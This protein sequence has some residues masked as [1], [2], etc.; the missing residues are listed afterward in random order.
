MK[1]SLIM[2]IVIGLPVAF[3]LCQT[4]QDTRLERGQDETFFVSF[5]T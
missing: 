3:S 4:A 1:Q 2:F 5:V